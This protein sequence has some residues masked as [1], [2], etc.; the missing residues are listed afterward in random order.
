MEHYDI[1]TPQ[2]NL[3]DI[4]TALKAGV[5]NFFEGLGLL[6]GAPCWLYHPI[7]MK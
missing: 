3:G 7:L 4:V 5:G 2:Y 6:F 1:F